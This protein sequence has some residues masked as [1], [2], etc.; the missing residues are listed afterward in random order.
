MPTTGI[1][2]WLCSLQFICEYR[3]TKIVV[4]MNILVT[5]SNVCFPIVL[6]LIFLVSR[7]YSPFA[8]FTEIYY[9]GICYV[10]YECINIQCLLHMSLFLCLPL[11]T[12]LT[13]CHHATL[14]TSLVCCSRDWSVLFH[15]GCRTNVQHYIGRDGFHHHWKRK[16]H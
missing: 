9:I 8:S 15:F 7:I 4:G 1:Y 10:I 6:D 12:Q 11:P 14:A 16:D 2:F 5:Q 3:Y 13:C